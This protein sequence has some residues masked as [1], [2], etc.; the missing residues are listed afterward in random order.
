MKHIPKTESV[1]IEVLS[2]EDAL[3]AKDDSYHYDR[4]KWIYVPDFYSEYR[5][6]LGTVGQKPLITIGIN[7]STAKPQ[8][9]DNTLKSVERIRKGSGFDSFVM[10]N[11][12]AQRATEP[13]LM[14]HIFNRK[15]HEENMKAFRWLLGR[16]Q[17]PSI[18][19]AWGT[20]IEQRTYLRECMRDMVAIA[21]EYGANWYKA[22]KVSSKGHPH[23]PLYLKADSKLEAFDVEE[24]LMLMYNEHELD[25]V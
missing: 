9:L 12:Y 11:V 7:P 3:K 4:E 16:C 23:H 20:V 13:K 18:W 19:A 25:Q 6:I 15:L 8:E 21:E 17:S 14:D 5:Y 1:N 2:F 10:F 24:Y 22:G